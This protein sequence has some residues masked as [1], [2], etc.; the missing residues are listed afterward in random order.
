MRRCVCPFL[1][2]NDLF[3]DLLIMLGRFGDYF[4]M[5]LESFWISSAC[6]QNIGAVLL[7]HQNW[8][9]DEI[10][11]LALLPQALGSKPNP[12]L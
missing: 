7:I 5:I 3:D 10:D 9:V 2:L 4:I 8:H 12:I 11:P 1:F 6:V